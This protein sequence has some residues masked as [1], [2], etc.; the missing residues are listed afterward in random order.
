MTEKQKTSI[1]DIHLRQTYHDEIYNYK[2][3]WILRWGITA[4]F[5]FIA[6]IIAVSGFIKYPD[7]VT[8]V[9][10]VTTI[11]PPVNLV[12]STSGK[13]KHVLVKEGQSVEEG[14]TLMVLE[15]PTHWED[16][17]TLEG[18]LLKLEGLLV[19]DSNTDL[20]NPNMFSDYLRLGEIQNYYSELKSSYGELYDY[21]HIGHLREKLRATRNQLSIQ[22][23]YDLQLKKKRKLVLNQLELGLK[24]LAR[25]KYLFEN[26]L[27]SE[28][29]VDISKQSNDLRF[30]SVLA[31]LDLNIT[32]NQ[33]KLDM[34]KEEIKSLILQEKADKQRLT[35]QLTKSLELVYAGVNVWK[36]KN[37]IDSPI[38]GHVSFN[39][40]WSENE[41]VKAGDVVISVLPS[42]ESTVKARIQFPVQN[43][44]KVAQGQ[45]V[46]IKLTS[47]PY[48][49]FGMLIGKMG[50]ISQVPTELAPAEFF[51]TADA[52]LIDGPITSYGEELPKV[53]QMVGTAEILTD[54]LSLLMRFFN[55]LRAIFD[56]RY[57]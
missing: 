50:T 32:S 30:R 25:D 48:Q 40:Y 2:A 52:L 36:Q 22:K 10:E 14:Q 21:Y 57:K 13:L 23:N 49:E 31:D 35:L 56:E 18:Y 51:Y 33:S 42:G 5:L 29:E 16:V 44:G 7:M 28:R 17:L 6:T 11:N 24:D 26:D 34:I 8:G 9:A 47:Y 41:F 3:P 38:E 19:D 15:S 39:S 20:Q 27:I 55:P 43:A 37:V 54:D 45:R 53:Q 46:N 1:S 12:S 4:V